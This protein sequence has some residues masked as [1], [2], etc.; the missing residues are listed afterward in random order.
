MT[1]DGQAVLEGLRVLERGQLA[2]FGGRLLASLGA[3]GVKEEG[4]DPVLAGWRDAGKRTTPLDGYDVVLDGRPPGVNGGKPDARALVR[5]TRFGE[6]G[7]WAGWCGDELASQALS[8]FMGLNGYAD[9]EPPLMCAGNQAEVTGGVMAA[10]ASM[11]LANGAGKRAATSWHEAL[12]VGHETELAAWTWR[13]ERLVRIAGRPASVN[14]SAPRLQWRCADNRYVNCIMPAL[15]RARWQ[16]IVEWKVCHRGGG[17][18]L[19]AACESSTSR[20]RSWARRQRAFSRRR[21]P[22]W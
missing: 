5:V 10:I 22:T 15:T 11:L 18:A 9:D 13:G 12:S 21:V 7:P 16:A 8:G 19:C 20:G 1:L 2:A 3:A 14:P 6:V 17:R 4:E